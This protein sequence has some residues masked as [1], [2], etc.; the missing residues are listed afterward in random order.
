MQKAQNRERTQ[1]HQQKMVFVKNAYFSIVQVTTEIENLISVTS[2]LAKQNHCDSLITRIYETMPDMSTLDDEPDPAPNFKKEDSIEKMRAQYRNA[3]FV[4]QFMRHILNVFVDQLH[5]K[6]SAPRPQLQELPSITMRTSFYNPNSESTQTVPPALPPLSQPTPTTASTISLNTILPSFHAPLLKTIT[7]PTPSTFSTLNPFAL[8]PLHLVQNTQPKAQPRS[9]APV[10]HSAKV[11]GKKGPPIWLPSLLD[12]EKTYQKSTQD[13]SKDS[14]QVNDPKSKGKRHKPRS[15]T[16]MIIHHS[17]PQIFPPSPNEGEQR[18]RFSFDF[19][20]DDLERDVFESDTSN[21]GASDVFTEPSPR[22]GRGGLAGEQVYFFGSGEKAHEDISFLDHI[23]P[24]ELHPLA[25]SFL[26]TSPVA[27]FQP[28]LSPSLQA[29]SSS[30]TR[31]ESNIFG[32]IDAPFLTDSDN[33]LFLGLYDDNPVDDAFRNSQRRA[34]EM[35][36]QN[37]RQ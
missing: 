32:W 30:T 26:H 14:K 6:D 21:F 3:S 20:S 8:T 25:S 34:R 19:D 35:N 15:H 1:K 10:P 24:T 33:P 16:S 36:E 11:V 37:K 28:P 13:P 2:Q 12:S 5:V 4:H 23:E 17:P 22:Q 31:S 9:H 18:V 7:N 29:I 27:P